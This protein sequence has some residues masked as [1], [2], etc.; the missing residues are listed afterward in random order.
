MA[1]LAGDPAHRGPLVVLA[2]DRHDQGTNAL[3]LRPPGI[4]PFQFGQESFPR[5]VALAQA[6]AAEVLV[7]RAP[8]TA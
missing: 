6:R 5:H 7:Y 3:L 1:A 8:G 4:L 2:P